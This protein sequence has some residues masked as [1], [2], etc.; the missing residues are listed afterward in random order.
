[1]LTNGHRSKTNYNTLSADATPASLNT[2]RQIIRV[3][4]TNDPLAIICTELLNRGQPPD[5]NNQFILTPDPASTSG[6][7]H[8]F[9]ALADKAGYSSLLGPRILPLAQW[10]NDLVMLT[11][12]I[13]HPSRLE[14]LVVEALQQHPSWCSHSESWQLAQ[15]LIPLFDEIARERITLPEQLARFKS[16]LQQGYQLSDEAPTGFSQEAKIV[17]ML[18]HAWRQQQ[19][20][21]GYIDAA[22][23]YTRQLAM[24]TDRIPDAHHLYLLGFRHFSAAE[25]AWL[26]MILQSGHATLVVQGLLSDRLEAFVS[27]VLN[28]Q[29]GPPR[30]GGNPGLPETPGKSHPVT[31][32]LDNIYAGLN[33][34]PTDENLAERMAR[35]GK[36]FRESPVVSHIKISPAANAEQSARIIELQ[37]LLWHTEGHQSIGIICE[38][39]RLS[40]RLRALLERRG[41][42]LHDQAGWALS[43]TSAATVLERLLQ[44]VEEDFDQTA[45]LDLLKSPF[46]LPEQP[47]ED[48]LQA[49][50]WL[51]RD[52]IRHENIQRGLWRYRA[53]IRYRQKRLAW[54]DNKHGQTINELLDTV[55]RSCAPLRE[56]LQRNSATPARYLAALRHALSGLGI[57][58]SYHL[59]A[60]GIAIT[61]TLER[62]SSVI[63]ACDMTLAWNDFR[64]WL[65]HTLE[66]ATFRPHSDQPAFH[67]GQPFRPEFP[68]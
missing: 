56:C 35:Y 1:M 14:L 37:L 23:A 41:F 27:S 50:F 15:S 40:R 51:E 67:L 22:T 42:S 30:N 45:L 33:G 7:Q 52:I 66:Q 38:D 2:G 55:E 16:T 9:L 32:F 21:C 29:E 64:Y 68:S 3:A 63:R 34:H 60:A 11:D 5:L 8:R 19:D 17:H 65:G 26:S 46:L 53:H 12:E 13:L 58:R 10:L 6:I 59:D 28:D 57:D 36:L 49:V 31:E 25:L 4:E 47:R 24:S 39:R 20:A 44:S 43:T 48:R 62:L 61:E 18:W 54:H